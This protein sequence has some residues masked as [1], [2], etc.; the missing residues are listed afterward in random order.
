[1][2]AAQAAARLLGL[3]RPGRPLVL[4][5]I[6]D[7]AGAR[8]VEEAGFGAVATSSAAVAESLGYRDHQ[9]APAEEMFAA[10]GRIA[11]A[12]S[13]PVTVD[14]EAGYGLPPQVLVDRLLA[15]GAAG[16]NLEDTDH[17]AGGLADPV[18]HAR[19]LAEVRAAAGDRLVINARVDVFLHAAGAPEEDML[20]AGLQRARRYLDSGA[21]CVYPIMARSPATIAR[22]VELGH[23]VNTLPRPGGPDLAA[24][25]GLGVARVSLAAGL[26]RAAQRWLAAELATLTPADWASSL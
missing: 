16:C 1:M 25:A 19:W 2:T 5:N 23:P 24:M 22:F 3:H 8:L 10:A 13:V 20:A 14:A 18:Q 12:V 9:G 6:W 17:Q 26:W 11:C 4:P 21:D 7:A 15:V